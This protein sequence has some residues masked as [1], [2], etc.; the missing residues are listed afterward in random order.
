MI[1]REFLE[2]ASVGKKCT[3]QEIELVRFARI[4]KI[5]EA[6]L[7]DTVSNLNRETPVPAQLTKPKESGKKEAI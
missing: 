1:E 2:L 7:I 5:V 3:I 4:Y 6:K